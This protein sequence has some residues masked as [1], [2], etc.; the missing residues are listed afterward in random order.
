MVPGVTTP[1]R[2]L[3]R[4]ERLAR[5]VGR[6]RRDMWARAATVLEREGE[7]LVHWQLISA[8]TREG[9]HSQVALAERVGMDPAGTSRALDALEREGLVSRERAEGDRRRVSV[10]LTPKGHRWFARVRVLVMGALAPLFE[11]LS[12]TDALQLEALLSRIETY[13]SESASGS[14][15]EGS[16]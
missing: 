15:N 9:L 11:R 14:I 3:D 2:R 13:S 4:T 12:P 7:L 16:V 6:L 5:A 10:N 8:I 1:A